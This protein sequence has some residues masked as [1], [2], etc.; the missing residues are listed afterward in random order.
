[1]VTVHI[2][3]PAARVLQAA[4]PFALM[5]LSDMALAQEGAPSGCAG[6]AV[7]LWLVYWLAVL[8]PVAAV[9]AIVFALAHSANKGW[10]IADALSEEVQLSKS[11]DEPLVLVTEMKASS[12]R[13]IALIGMI[14]ILIVYVSFASVLL[15]M[16]GQTCAVPAAIDKVYWFL[17]SGAALFAPYAINKFASLFDALLPKK[18]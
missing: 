13:F 11:K 18:G 10:S 2:P 9:L 15:V 6:A 3:M 1:M 17:V 16:F 4:V 7:P 12:S 5:L 8:I 14:A